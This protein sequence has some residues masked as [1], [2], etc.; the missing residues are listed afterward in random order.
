MS[1]IKAL[2]HPTDVR[3]SCV[4]CGFEMHLVVKGHTFSRFTIPWASTVKLILRRE[5]KFPIQNA[6]HVNEDIFYHE[7]CNEKKSS[8]H[9]S[10]LNYYLEKFNIIRREKLT[11]MTLH[12]SN[13]LV[14]LLNTDYHNSFIAYIVWMKDDQMLRLTWNLYC[15]SFFVSQLNIIYV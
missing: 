7:T 11:G 15:Y 6:I 10:L 9:H 4:F 12:V 3:R 8:Y 14:L 1:R 13:E 5:A 2:L